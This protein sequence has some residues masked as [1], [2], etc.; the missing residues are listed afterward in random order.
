MERAARSGGDVLLAG[1]GKE[2]LPKL[3]RQT[4]PSCCRRGSRSLIWGS[5]AW[6]G[7]LAM[8]RDPL[9]LEHTEDAAGTHP[10]VGS[11]WESTLL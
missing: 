2:L 1:A 5:Q 11:A 3:L 6:R 9:M 7:V 8:G 4:L 10:Q